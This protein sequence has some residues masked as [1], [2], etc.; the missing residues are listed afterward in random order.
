MGNWDGARFYPLWY[1]HYDGS[2]SYS[3]FVPFGGWTSPS[4]KQF[5]GDSWICN[6]EVDQNWYP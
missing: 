3:D 4:M 6:V 2:P 5:A 1:P